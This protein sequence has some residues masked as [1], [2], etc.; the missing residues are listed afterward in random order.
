MSKYRNDINLLVIV[1]C[2]PCPV[3]RASS[4]KHVRSTIS[5]SDFRIKGWVDKDKK[6]FHNIKQ[7]LM[8]QDTRKEDL[9]AS[10]ERRAVWKDTKDASLPEYGLHGRI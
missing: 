10:T 7:K 8:L 9:N 4:S 3:Y 2:R 1:F 6:F 5:L